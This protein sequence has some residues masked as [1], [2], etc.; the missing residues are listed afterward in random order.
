[1]SYSDDNDIDEPTRNAYESAS[2]EDKEMLREN[3][4]Q[5]KK[6]EAE[7]DA[8]KTK[9]KIRAKT[10]DQ[11]HAVTFDLEAVLTTPHAGDAQIYYK[12]KLAVYNFTI[13][14][15]A[16]AWSVL[17]LDETEGGRG[18]NE[19]ATNVLH[20]LR[21]LPTS[22]HHF[23]SFSDT[24]GGQNRNQFMAGAMLYAVQ[25]LT[26]L[27]TIDLKYMESG[28]S[29][30]EVDSMHATIDVSRKHQKVYTT[31]EWEILIKGARKRPGPYDVKIMHH[32]DFLN[33]KEVTGMII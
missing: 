20:Y 26:N 4:E 1:M 15:A 18:A 23:S 19:I 17:P 9:D 3:W 10:D 21:N 12:Q 14:D 30:L 33:I 8:E 25:S 5:H 16:T 31:R 29:C 28:H 32:K 13:Y 11:Y 24:C 2:A 7:A 27:E 6:R 22:V